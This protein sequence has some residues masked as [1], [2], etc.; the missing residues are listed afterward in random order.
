M[1][2]ERGN[3]LEND[4]EISPEGNKTKRLG[5]N[6]PQGIG[7]ALRS[8]FEA[9]DPA[10]PDGSVTPEDSVICCNNFCVFV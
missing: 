8:A 9:L 3:P 1:P 4:N 7:E 6:I 2:S 10:M 5:G